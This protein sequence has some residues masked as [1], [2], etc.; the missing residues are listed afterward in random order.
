MSRT[1]RRSG[2]S[3][4]VGAAV[5]GSAASLHRRPSAPGID[6][7]TLVVDPATEPEGLGGRGWRWIS[8]STHRLEAGTS[9]GRAGDERE[10][11]VV[12]IEGTVSIEVAGRSFGDVGG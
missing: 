8:F 11:A 1:S 7:T 12:V 10:I 5:T 4:P 2:G 6:G 3:D 9:I